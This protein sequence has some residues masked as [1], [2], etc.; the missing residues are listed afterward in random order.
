MEGYSLV[1]ES[2]SLPISKRPMDG[3][4]P[5]IIAK[6]MVNDR[7]LQATHWRVDAVEYLLS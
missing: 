6:G 3:I 1:K 7:A 5:P 2:T 4:V